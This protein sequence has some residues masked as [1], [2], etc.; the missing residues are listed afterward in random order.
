MKILGRVQELKAD[1]LPENRQSGYIKVSYLDKKGKAGVLTVALD[2]ESYAKAIEAHQKG[3]YVSLEH[4][5]GG[6]VL[7]FVIKI[8]IRA[9]EYAIPL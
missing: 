6:G 9:A 2:A 4:I 5:T 1:P 7:F 8:G 3:L